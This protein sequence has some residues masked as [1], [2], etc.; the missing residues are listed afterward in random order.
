M[1]TKTDQLVQS[2][3]KF[4]TF[5]KEMNDLC[6]FSKYYITIKVFF[7]V[8]DGLGNSLVLCKYIFFSEHSATLNHIFI[9]I[10]NV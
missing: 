10:H 2:T 6:L 9:I 3:K 1:F 5:N 7:S 8:T 4:N